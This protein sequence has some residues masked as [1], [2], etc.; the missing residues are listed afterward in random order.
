M[1]CPKCGDPLHALPEHEK[2]DKQKKQELL[3]L[4]RKF[5]KIL[6]KPVNSREVNEYVK[7]FRQKEVSRK[8]K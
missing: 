6:G 5:A 2:S 3:L 4:Q 1:R 7:V 8:S